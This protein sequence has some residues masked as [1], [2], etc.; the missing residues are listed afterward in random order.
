MHSMSEKPWKC[1]P[2]FLFCPEARTLFNGRTIL[3]LFRGHTAHSG[4]HTTRLGGGGRHAFFKYEATGFSE[5]SRPSHPHAN[6]SHKPQAGRVESPACGI[7]LNE[8][9]PE[10]FLSNLSF[11]QD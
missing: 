1:L 5:A 10:P 2:W 4:E 3:R 9:A 8:T 7:S 11:A 6:L